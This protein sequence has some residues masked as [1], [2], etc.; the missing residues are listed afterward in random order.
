MPSLPPARDRDSALIGRLRRGERAAAA[1]LLDRELEPLYEF[2]HWRLGP[3]RDAADDLVQDTFVVA[4]R[5]LEEFDARA[6]LH[7][8]LCG[9]ARNKIRELRRSRGG[10]RARMRP[11]EDVL[12][13]SDDEIDR[14][15]AE[16]ERTEIPDA[17]LERRETRELVGAALSSLPPDYKAALLAKYVEELSVDE[18]AARSGRSTKA[19]ESLLGR[20]RTAFAKVFELL[21]RRR[22]ELE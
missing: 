16:V 4:L 13:E 5:R 8:W 14:I 6:S 10:G 15:L 1:E 19:A 2:V 3:D 21:A 22:G 17:V 18:I 12:A 9:I 20:A 11:I 7:T